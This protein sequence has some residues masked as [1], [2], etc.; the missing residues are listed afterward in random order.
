MRRSTLLILSLVVA[1]SPDLTGLEQ[2]L[3]GLACPSTG[4]CARRGGDWPT[5]TFRYRIEGFPPELVDRS[6]PPSTQGYPGR[7]PAGDSF[8]LYVVQ[9]TSHGWT[10]TLRAVAWSTT[11]TTVARIESEPSGRGLFTAVAPGTVGVRAYGAAHQVWA[12]PEGGICRRKVDRI[13]VVPAET[14]G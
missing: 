6:V 12:C 1:C 4:R 3:D 13:A 5:G 11:D 9:R 14:G 2:S 8:G 10:D 7:V